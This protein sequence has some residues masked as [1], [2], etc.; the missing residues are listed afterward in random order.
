MAAPPPA[1]PE[2]S[3]KEHLSS[4][5]EPTLDLKADEAALLPGENVCQL[6][7]TCHVRWAHGA[8]CRLFAE[9]QG[10]VATSRTINS[11]G[12]TLAALLSSTSNTDLGFINHPVSR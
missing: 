12:V 8:K 4:S 10:L 11:L 9:S 2:Q 1:D 6:G 3:L 7:P 5:S